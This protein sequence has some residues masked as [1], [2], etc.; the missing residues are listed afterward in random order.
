[1]RPYPAFMALP[2]SAEIV[3]FH[4]RAICVRQLQPEDRSL[5][6]ELV[7]QTELHDLQMRFFG[8][9]RDLPPDLLDHLMRI[10]PQQRIALV[11][12]SYRSSGIPEIL[13]VGRAHAV[14]RGSAELAL[15]VRSDLK[16]LGLGSLLLERLIRCCRR[17][18]VSR[19]EADVLHENAPMLRLAHRYGFRREAVQQEVTHLVLELSSLA[20]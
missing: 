14:A 1:M 9:F 2:D 20:A 5:L 19:L 17:R 6:E 13:A 18:G 12:A 16:G 4:G 3:A 10:D 15:L 11:A 8:G 7:A